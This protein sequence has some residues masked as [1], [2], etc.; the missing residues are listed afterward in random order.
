MLGVKWGFPDECS[1]GV[2][3]GRITYQ[4]PDSAWVAYHG[5]AWSPWGGALE[6]LLL[7]VIFEDLV[8]PLGVEG[9]VDEDA[10]LVGSRTAS[11]MD[12][13]AHNHLALP[14]LADQ[15]TAVVPLQAHTP[16]DRKSQLFGGDQNHIAVF[17]K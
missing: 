4:L 5:H 15:R 14:V 16:K 7:G 10:G 12:A 1:R 8:D 17:L 2:T 9:D 3:Q 13:D 6:G 11:A